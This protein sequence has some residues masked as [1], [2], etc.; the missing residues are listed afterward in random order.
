M[1]KV[2]VILTAVYDDGKSVKN[3]GDQ[4]SMDDKL[5]MQLADLGMVKLPARE[6]KQPKGK[7]TGEDADPQPGNAPLPDPDTLDPDTGDGEDGEGED[8]V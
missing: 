1:A 2:T 8:H 7:K 3:P 6:G 4:V 5:A